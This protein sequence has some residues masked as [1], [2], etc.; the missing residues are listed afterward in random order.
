MEHILRVHNVRDQLELLRRLYVQTCRGVTGNGGDDNSKLDERVELALAKMA[1][2]SKDRRVQLLASLVLLS[3]SAGERLLAIEE[4]A[5]LRALCGDKKSDICVGIPLLAVL[6]SSQFHARALS[7]L[8]T[9]ALDS[10]CHSLTALVGLARRERCSHLNGGGGGVSLLLGENQSNLRAVERV[11]FDCLLNAERFTVASQ[12]RD[13]S[14][15]SSSSS[16]P[17]SGGSKLFGLAAAAIGARHSAPEPVV[18]LDGTVAHD[19]FTVLN[20]AASADVACYSAAQIGNNVAFSVL[21]EWLL[22]LYVAADN[23]RGDNATTTTTTLSKRI[24]D[25]I[26][27]YGTRLAEQAKHAAERVPSASVH[28]RCNA[29]LLECVRI[30]D[31]VCELDAA[32]TP[33]V[34]PLVR[35]L[36]SRLLLGNAAAAGTSAA[37][38]TSSSAGGGESAAM[39]CIGVT[40][41]LVRH[42]RSVNFDVEP[43]LVYLFEHV[44]A[45]FWMPHVAFEVLQFCVDNKLHL[46]AERYRFEPASISVAMNNNDKTAD[47]ANKGDFVDNDNN[48][49]NGNND[50]D[51]DD[52]DDDHSHSSILGRYFPQLLKLCA[53]YPRSLRAEMIE[54]LPVMVDPSSYVELLHAVL[55]LPLTSL[56]LE[57]QL[58]GGARAKSSAEASLRV[59]YNYLLRADS[60]VPARLFWGSTAMQPLLELFCDVPPT[61]RVLAA[62][63]F[64]PLLLKQL[65]DVASNYGGLPTVRRLMPIAFRRLEQLYPMPSFRRAIEA[66]VV[67]HVRR[68]F[69]RWPSLIV[70]AKD[71]VI[72]VLGDSSSDGRQEL[73]LTLVWLV[74]ELAD[75]VQ[76]Q[77]SPE[78][79]NEYHEVL[80]L[81]IYERSSYVRAGEDASPDATTRLMIVL[82]YAVAKLAARF[83]DLASRVMLCLAKVI[84][85]GDYFDPIVIQ[86]ASEAINLLKFPSVASAILASSSSSSSSSSP[87]SSLSSSFHV[88]QSSALPFLLQSSQFSSQSLHSFR[89]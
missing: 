1:L 21:Y 28:A 79:L 52:D 89:L 88:D 60:G 5:G 71:I 56:A 53:W 74:G 38:S 3:L 2:G 46:V 11:M 75:P 87:S 63:D 55:D 78:L 80:E 36:H 72:E 62:A 69:G 7:D 73:I 51:D 34:F 41:F 82:Q 44:A 25:A 84:R 68:A 57:R 59:L 47:G 14:S 48:N 30:F 4:A 58:M 31:I 20:D 85:D 16:S 24:V 70:S 49:S 40:H 66:V 9:W 67:E 86:R 23:D 42:H 29:A 45:L 83:P 50:D 81:F 37:S 8:V 33:L 35:R 61:A 65:L 76:R 32:Q 18:E 13:E 10:Y 77:C 6:G 19:F 26:V 39:L 43:A 17:S 64:A 22:Y 54:L 12:R 27:K 15:S